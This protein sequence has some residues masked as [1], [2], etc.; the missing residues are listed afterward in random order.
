MAKI[1][2]LKTNYQPTER[3]S[4]DDIDRMADY[5]NATIV[6]TIIDKG[7]NIS[8]IRAFFNASIERA[9]ALRESKATSKRFS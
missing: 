2:Q 8:D 6:S 7:I 1:L 4:K 3:F 9:C 5:L